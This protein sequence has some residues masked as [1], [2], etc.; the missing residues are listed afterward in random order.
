MHVNDLTLYFL[1]HLAEKIMQHVDVRVNWIQ[2]D[3]ESLLH[4]DVP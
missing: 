1:L 2:T 3:P 4:N